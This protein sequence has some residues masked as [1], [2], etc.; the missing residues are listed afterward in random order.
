[1]LLW[2]PG[3]LCGATM[4][5]WGVCQDG[6]QH[7]AALRVTWYAQGDCGLRVHVST[8][9]EQHATQDREE[10]FQAMGNLLVFPL[11]L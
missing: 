2:T 9:L 11:S 6:M 10:D 3:M 8:Q 1:M 7:G 4:T 5:S